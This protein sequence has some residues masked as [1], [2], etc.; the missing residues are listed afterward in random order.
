M[1]LSV[2][3][4][5]NMPKP[6][7]TGVEWHCFRALQKQTDKNMF[8][9]ANESNKLGQSF[10]VN[11]ILHQGFS[12]IRIIKQ[13]VLTKWC[14]SYDVKIITH[15]ATIIKQD[16]VLTKWCDSYDLKKIT[17]TATIIKQYKVTKWSDKQCTCGVG[18]QGKRQLIITY[19]KIIISGEKVIIYEKTK[20]RHFINVD[21]F[22][23]WCHYIII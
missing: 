16:K 10:N 15:K 21:M 22:T 4:P 6:I 13:D 7:L 19:W 1:S 3:V 8:K 2:I 5:S 17:H 11:A 12:T 9:L 18:F 23:K 14:D 20:H